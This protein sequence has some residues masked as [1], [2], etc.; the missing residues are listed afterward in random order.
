MAQGMDE[1]EKLYGELEDSFRSGNYAE[2]S[3]IMTNLKI[4]LLSL[5]TTR[6]SDLLLGQRTLEVAALL[7]I[8]MSD[9]AG[10]QRN[11]SQLKAYYAIPGVATKSN[12]RQTVLGL[13]L[14]FLIVENR[15]A[16]FHSELE[17]MTSADLSSRE[18]AFSISLEQFLMVGTYNQVMTSP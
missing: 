17:L 16:E 13:Y 6:E 2:A 3:T 9:T 4:L 18:I 12:L 11:V 7:S 8:Q 15:L 1:G 5:Q 14:L 10:F